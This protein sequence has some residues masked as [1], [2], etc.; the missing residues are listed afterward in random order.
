MFLQITDQDKVKY[1][2]QELLTS[3]SKY[4]IENFDNENQVFKTILTQNQTQRFIYQL[5]QEDCQ[6]NGYFFQNTQVV[7]ITGM[8][9]R[10]S[11]Y[12]CPVYW[13]SQPSFYTRNLE[14]T[15]KIWGFFRLKAAIVNLFL[16]LEKHNFFINSH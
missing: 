7:L 2:G 9:A 11:C 14:L 16:L 3:S 6:P 8:L 10:S 12:S 4:L 13:K 15:P 5:P 1:K